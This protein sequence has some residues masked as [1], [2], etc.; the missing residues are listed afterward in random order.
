MV[1]DDN[2]QGE[3]STAQVGKGRSSRRSENSSDGEER[4]DLLKQGASID[5]DDSASDK[6][7]VMEE[8]NSHLY[9]ELLDGILKMKDGSGRLICELFLKLPPRSVSIFLCNYKQCNPKSCG[10]A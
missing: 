5:G 2:Q 1:T 3:E 7:S 8:T 6:G 10:V 9:Q 4:Q